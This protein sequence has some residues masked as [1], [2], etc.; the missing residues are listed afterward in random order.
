M[1][2]VSA[3]NGTVALHFIGDDVTPPRG[4]MTRDLINFITAYYHFNVFP[5]IPQGIPPSLIQ[6][7]HFQSGFMAADADKFPI[8]QLSIIP[9]GELVTAVTTEAADIILD[10]LIAR[11]D[12]QF[13]YKFGK[14]KT[15]RTYLSNFTV[16]FDGGFEKKIDAFA[17]IE[18]ILNEHIPRPSMPFKIK[19]LAFGGGEPLPLS[20]PMSLDAVDNADFMIERRSGTPYSENRFFCS[21]PVRTADHLALLERIEKEFGS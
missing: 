10:D 19:R 6:S 17:R 21:A 3:I 13:G 7:Y 14:A 18:S 1:K 20:T 15:R 16:Q 9:N 12:E 4:L 8:V 11:L 2:F 5:Q